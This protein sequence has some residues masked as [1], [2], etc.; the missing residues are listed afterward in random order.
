MNVCGISTKELMQCVFLI[1]YNCLWNEL[2][3]AITNRTLQRIIVILL[4]HVISADVGQAH[5]PSL[6][7]PLRTFN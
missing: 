2:G 7:A 5:I 3:V 4:T 6:T 1:T